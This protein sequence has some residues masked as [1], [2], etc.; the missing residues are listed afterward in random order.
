MLS[1]QLEPEVMDTAEEAAD[2]DA[3]DHR[4]VNRRYVDDLLREAASR[5][6][7]P[8]RVLDVGTGTALIPIELCR[9]AG[10]TC[11]VLG[12]DL[13]DA[14]LAQG[15]RNVDRAGLVD[16]IQLKRLDAKDLPLPDAAFDI[17]M[18]NSIIHHIPEPSACLAE[19]VRLVRIGGLLFVRDLFRPESGADVERLVSQYAGS[20]SQRQQQL[21]RQSLHASLTVDEVRSLTTPL[22][23][24]SE[25]IRAT[26]DR[27]WTL[28]WVHEE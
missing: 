3:M 27:H 14:M 13:A 16:R 15:R 8:G 22:G 4:E 28:T 9:Q 1:R 12:I 6:I 20:E 21:F 10:S 26:S 5:T 11:E 2:Y 17:V 18:S 19:M 7:R 25:A 23:I 24:A